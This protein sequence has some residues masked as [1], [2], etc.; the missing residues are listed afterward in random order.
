[1]NTPA[2]IAMARAV[3]R[4]DASSHIPKASWL[5]PAEQRVLLRREIC[6]TYATPASPAP[7]KPAI[8]VAVIIAA[9]MIEARRDAG[10]L[11]E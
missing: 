1:M 2:S 5:M 3:V 11:P 7:T 6:G 8:S 4:R 10:G 9:A